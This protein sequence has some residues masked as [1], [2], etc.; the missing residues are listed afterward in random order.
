MSRC[1]RAENFHHTIL[2]KFSLPGLC[3]CGQAPGK[4]HLSPV[5]HLQVTCGLPVFHL[6]VTCG[7]PAGHLWAPCGPL[8]CD[9]KLP[10]IV[11][12]MITPPPHTHFCNHSSASLPP[13]SPS[14]C[15]PHL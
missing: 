2:K 15:A 8:A 6:Q 4:T 14:F 11:L 12:S 1:C 10:K 5:G 13:L 3:S 7:L 9:Y